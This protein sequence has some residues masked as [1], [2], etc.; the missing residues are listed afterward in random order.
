MDRTAR[1]TLSN[2]LIV[3]LLSCTILNASSLSAIAQ[4]IDSG[5]F[6][7]RILPNHTNRNGQGGA[8]IRVAGKANASINGA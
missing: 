3:S 4:V 8:V 7:Q 6:L 2:A 5:N 1:K